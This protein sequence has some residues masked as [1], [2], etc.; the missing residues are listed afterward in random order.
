MCDLGIMPRS[1]IHDLDAGIAT[2]TIQHNSWQ[3]VLVRRFPY[4]IRIAFVIIRSNT[5]TSLT[6]LDKF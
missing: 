6:I 1:N 5:C 4:C 2:D 3:S